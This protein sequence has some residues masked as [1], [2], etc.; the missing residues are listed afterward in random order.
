M[1][2]WIVLIIL[3][4]CMILF[5]KDLIPPELVSI[6]ALLTL[7]VSRVLTSQEAFSGFGDPALI[8]IAS[9]FVLSAGLVRTGVV[10][11]VGRKIE[12][13]AG[14]NYTFLLALCMLVVVTIS[15]FI[16][17][18]AATAVMLPVALGISNRTSIHPGKFLM[19]IAF[20]SMLGGTCTAIGTSTNV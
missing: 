6:I 9:V 18:V 19:P 11:F 17:N 2:V 4:V 1:E 16:N 14:T 15:A 20:G 13:L 5:M 12:Q 3:A 10:D 8:T 7:V